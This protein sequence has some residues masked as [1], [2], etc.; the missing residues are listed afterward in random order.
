MTVSGAFSFRIHRQ[1]CDDPI[2]DV[3]LVSSCRLHMLNTGKGYNV[4]FINERYPCIRTIQPQLP[5]LFPFRP[6]PYLAAALL[7]SKKYFTSIVHLRP[8]STNQWTLQV[9][10]FSIIRCFNAE[11]ET[12]VKHLLSTL[13]SCFAFQSRGRWFLCEFSSSSSSSSSS[14]RFWGF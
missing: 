6:D 4:L 9:N 2:R 3:V 7:T 1:M 5:I 10:L 13:A 8:S 11:F 14:V 12:Y